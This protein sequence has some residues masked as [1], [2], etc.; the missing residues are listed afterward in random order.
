MWGTGPRDVWAVGDYGVTLHWDGTDWL[1]LYP[2]SPNA[3][4]MPTSHHLRGIWGTPDGQVRV[5]GEGGV[6]LVR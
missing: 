1:Y 6:I 2:G 4:R 3:S 5:V